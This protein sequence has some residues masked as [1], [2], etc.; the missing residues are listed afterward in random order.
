MG[1]WLSRHANHGCFTIPIWLVGLLHAR[2]EATSGIWCFQLSA[3]DVVPKP[4]KE[5]FLRSV[6]T[7]KQTMAVLGT[8]G[9]TYVF[10][11]MAA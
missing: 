2:L 9:R 11:K 4:R 8:L 3:A 1:F 10:T 5:I 7:I 6:V